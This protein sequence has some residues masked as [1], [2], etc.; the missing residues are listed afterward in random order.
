MCVSD[1]YEYTPWLNI[2]DLKLKFAASHTIQS[3]NSYPMSI[4]RPCFDIYSP[5]YSPVCPISLGNGP[6]GYLWPRTTSKALTCS[7]KVIH[8]N[9]RWKPVYWF[10]MCGPHIPAPMQNRC[11]K[12]LCHWNSRHSGQMSMKLKTSICY[13]A[14]GSLCKVVPTSLQQNALQTAHS[15]ISMP[16]ISMKVL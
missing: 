4:T 14:K 13:L 11:L 12:Y 6:V 8:V 15:S 9:Y 7:Y 5:Q 10:K 3:S 16:P 1:I 2:Y